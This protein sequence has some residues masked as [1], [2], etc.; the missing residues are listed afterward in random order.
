M[1]SNLA[2]EGL[3]THQIRTSEELAGWLLSH[4]FAQS[5][6]SLLSLD[7]LCATNVLTAL[8][9][10]SF[11][12]E[13]SIELNHFER[14]EFLGDAVLDLIVSSDLFDRYPSKSEGELSKARSLL[15]NA[16]SLT[17]L[18]I[19]L[20]WHQ[21]MLV[22]KSFQES[23]L[24]KHPTLLADSLESLLGVAYL[25]KGFDFAREIFSRMVANWEEKTDKS[26]YQS[27]ESEQSDPKGALQ[28]FTVKTFGEYPQYLA[29][30]VKPGM[31]EVTLMIK[32]LIVESLVS[33]SKKKCERQL[34][35]LALNK[36]Q[37]ILKSLKER[38]C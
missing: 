34:A 28:E 10:S 32:D 38:L 8:T 9:H 24:M 26:F 12:N 29:K 22:S 5:F 2:R 3:F 16:E 18:A 7:Q 13:S 27:F 17:S 11:I 6:V 20:N 30:E 36:K 25:E 15:V 4:S 21:Y 1:L 19:E 35:A 23:D 14:L 37:E 31:F 33:E